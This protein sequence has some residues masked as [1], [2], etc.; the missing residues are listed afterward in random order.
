MENFRAIS[1]QK[2]EAGF[3]KHMSAVLS[4]QVTL[5]INLFYTLTSVL[6]Q[7]YTSG[8]SIP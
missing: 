7:A 5:A 3:E 2:L 4:C 8:K 1:P 6:D